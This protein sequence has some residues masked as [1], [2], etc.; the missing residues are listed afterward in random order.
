M[1]E[2]VPFDADSQSAQDLSPAYLPQQGTYQYAD[3]KIVDCY[4]LWNTDSIK[5][6][7]VT[8]KEFDEED[9]L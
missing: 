7:I 6:S 4:V 5:N 9:I 1:P 3:G 8:Y 2:A